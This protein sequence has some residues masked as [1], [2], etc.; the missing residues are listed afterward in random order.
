MNTSDNRNSAR[1]HIR[2]QGN[3]NHHGLLYQAGRDMYIGGSR[4]ES[5]N[6]APPRQLPWWWAALTALMLGGLFLSFERERIQEHPTFLAAFLAGST[7]LFVVAL[8]GIRYMATLVAFLAAHADRGLRHAFSRYRRQY[9]EFLLRTHHDMDVRG[10]P[11]RGSFTLSLEQVYVDLRLTHR[12]VHEATSH[13]TSDRLRLTEWERQSVWMALEKEYPAPLAVIGAPGSGKTTLLKH[14]ARRMCEKN[15]QRFV[16]RRRTALLPILLFLREHAQAIIHDER[17]TVP[18]LVRSTLSRLRGKEPPGWLERQLEKGRCLVMFDGLD[19]VA[20]P[21]HRRRIVEWV[22]R[23]VNE[24][25]N[26][27]YILT[28]RPHGYRSHPLNC[29]TVVQVLPFTQQQ[30]NKFVG[31]WYL[32]TTFRST[33]RQDEGARATA[34]EDAEDLLRRLRSMPALR[35]LSANPLLLTMI[36]NV[37]Y[38]RSALPGSRA[39]LYRDICQVFLGKRQEAKGLARELTADQQELVLRHLAY[40]MM[41]RR[42]RALSKADASAVISTVLQGVKRDL[43]PGD[44]LSAV[45]ADSGM[46]LEQESGFFG[47]AHLTFQEYLAATHIRENGFI[48]SL[49]PEIADPWWRETILLYVAQA[50]ADPIVANCLNHYSGN[51]DILALAADCA[52]EAR[53]LSPELRTRLEEVLSSEAAQDD[54]VRRRLIAKTMLT[55]KLRRTV[56]LERGGYLCSF[57]VTNAEFNFFLRDIEFGEESRTPDHRHAH[58]LG[59]ASLPVSGVRSSDAAAFV[60]WARSLG[61]N[62]RLP[63]AEELIASDASDRTFNPSKQAAWVTGRAVPSA[64]ERLRPGLA[65]AAGATTT[66]TVDSRSLESSGRL[67]VGLQELAAAGRLPGKIDGSVGLRA[68]RLSAPHAPVVELRTQRRPGLTTPSAH[69]DSAALALTEMGRPAKVLDAVTTLAA[70]I[71][72]DARA[73]QY[74]FLT[75]GDAGMRHIAESSVERDLVSRTLITYRR[76]VTDLAMNSVEFSSERAQMLVRRVFAALQRTPEHHTKLAPYAHR[77]AGRPQ[78]SDKLPQLER[79]A[80]IMINQIDVDNILD[81]AYNAHG[82]AGAWL[83]QIQDRTDMGMTTQISRWVIAHSIN[84]AVTRTQAGATKPWIQAG[85]RSLA[86]LA[87]VDL[88][89]CLSH[90]PRNVYS[91][92]HLDHFEGV[93]LKM[94]AD[95]AVLEERLDGALPATEVLLLVQE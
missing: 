5:W 82:E 83:G 46:L 61:F 8:V 16:V 11:T 31:N 86:R 14:V 85:M 43:S 81:M 54:V 1:P 69:L 9:C 89:T 59:D 94:L 50:D 10:L 20:H 32:E 75:G 60:L 95:M 92:A 55:R 45:E 28:S 21:D 34:E 25:S 73:L 27:Y 18:D 44:F 57:P 47:F 68:R 84:A 72:F 17:V 7:L 51:V 88:L 6:N 58:D 67:I 80:A 52:E 33:N 48:S 87:V 38:Y 24:Y 29:A 78:Q 76:L 41:K 71:E 90:L 40:E 91:A 65:A 19:E 56:P 26:N 74:A 77:S 39:E 30:I 66:L 13:P 35:T 42:A 23:Q 62:V 36:A 63:A 64:F 12:S 37:H 70:R 22:Q 49:A 3:A 2:Q 79:A 15:T 4:P 93:Y 53:Q